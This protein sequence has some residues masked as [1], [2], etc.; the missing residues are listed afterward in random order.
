MKRGKLE[1]SI[2]YD[3]LNERNKLLASAIIEKGYGYLFKSFVSDGS[4]LMISVPCLPEETIENA[5]ARMMKIVSKFQKQD[6][7]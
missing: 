3:S 2:N 1:I 4:D 6:I 7:V 5:N